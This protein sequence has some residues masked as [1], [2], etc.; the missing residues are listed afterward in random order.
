MNTISRKSDIYNKHLHTYTRAH[1]C[2]HYKYTHVHTHIHL[3]TFNKI[4]IN[5]ITGITDIRALKK[6]TQLKQAI[7]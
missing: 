2:R 4:S 1:V 5:N 3:H 7:M 6:M